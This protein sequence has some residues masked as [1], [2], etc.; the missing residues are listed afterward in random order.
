METDAVLTAIHLK[1]ILQ[2]LTQTMAA[3]ETVSR[4]TIG[5]KQHLFSHFQQNYPLH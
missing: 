2:S 4:I 1:K 3:Q 5:G